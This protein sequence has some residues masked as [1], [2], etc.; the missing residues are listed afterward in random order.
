MA[1]IMRRL[2][3]RQ[4]E[5]LLCDEVAGERRG[6]AVKK[7]FEARMIRWNALLNPC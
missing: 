2:P 7:E 3:H 1:C 4:E 5:T 6:P